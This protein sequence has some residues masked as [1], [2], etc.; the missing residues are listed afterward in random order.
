VRVLLWLAECKRDDPGAAR[1]NDPSREVRIV[2][3]QPLAGRVPYDGCYGLVEPA[4]RGQGR[5]GPCRWDKVQ[6]AGPSS[7]VVYWFGG[8]GQLDRVEAEHTDD[9]VFITV[10]EERA[11]RMAGRSKAALVHLDE[12]LRGRQVRR[13]TAQ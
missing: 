6:I 7:L 3:D 13:G 1:G 4:G 10:I 8:M 2:L 12:P 9:S 5:S 11:R